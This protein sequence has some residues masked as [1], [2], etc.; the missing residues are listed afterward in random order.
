VI[1]PDRRFRDFGC[2]RAL[3]PAKERQQIAF[4]VSSVGSLDELVRWRWLGDKYG[5]AVIRPLTFVVL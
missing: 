3:F 5:Y 2:C 1:L 4:F